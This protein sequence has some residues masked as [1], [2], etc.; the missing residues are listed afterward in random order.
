MAGRAAHTL[1][2]RQ[3]AVMHRIDRRVPIKLIANEM[4]VSETRINQHIRALKKIY[5]VASLNELVECYRAHG[6]EGGL[7]GQPQ[8]A[9]N[10]HFFE[11]EGPFRKPVYSKKQLQNSA[12]LGNQ[13]DRDDPGLIRMSD[14]HV[15]ARDAL[16]AHD[17]E[18]VVVF[19]ALDGKHAI[20][21]RFAVMIGIAL[22][23][24][25]ALVLVVSAGLALSEVLDDKAQIPVDANG[26]AE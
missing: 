14:A 2:D 6:P 15:V 8:D 11:D 26:V 13:S 19:G 9:Q 23:V 12:G 7:N 22:G 17:N 25:A 16:W 4:G 3:R 10:D 21:Y 1:T 20:L 24:V 18:P 5:G